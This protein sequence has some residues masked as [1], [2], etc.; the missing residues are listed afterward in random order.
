VQTC[1]LP[2][3]ISTWL[4]N[5]T[6]SGN[7]SA[8]FFGSDQGPFPE[9][10]WL[11]NPSDPSGRFKSVLTNSLNADA[12]WGTEYGIS[13]SDAS[14]GIPG[15]VT[16]GDWARDTTVTP[17]TSLTGYNNGPGSGRVDPDRAVR[18]VDTRR[19]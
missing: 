2:I 16:D 18:A 19:G 8:L 13:P 11:L 17:P 5:E 9:Q 10:Y 14:H 15:P 12:P 6:G 1:A 3:S 7:Y 4:R